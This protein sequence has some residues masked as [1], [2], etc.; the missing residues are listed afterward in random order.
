MLLVGAMLSVG[1]LAAQEVDLALALL[2]DSSGSIDATEFNLQKSGYVDAFNS[3]G[4]WD[5]INDGEQGRIAA[6]FAYWSS[7]FQF[8]QAVGWTVIDDFSASQSFAS[9][10]AATS[11][12][13]SGGT[14]IGSAL[15]NG[16]ALFGDLGGLGISTSRWVIDISGDG[17]SFNSASGRANAVAAGVDQINGLVIGPSTFLRDH[18]ENEVVT[19]DGFVQVA[20]GFDTFGDAIEEKIVRE[21]SEDP[22]VTTPEPSSATLLLGVGILGYGFVR[23]RQGMKRHA[24]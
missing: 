19:D 17:I 21:V 3:S 8:Q 16:A 9:D 20:T 22:V 15:T 13:F 24:A 6:T 2:V 10:I 18:Y 4:V 5:A 12:P 1:G 14:N 7:S 23:R 11:R